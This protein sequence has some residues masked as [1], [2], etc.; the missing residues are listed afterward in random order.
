[1]Q[2]SVSNKRFNPPLETGVACWHRHR[3]RHG[4][5]VHAKRF[6][7]ATGAT[8][9]GALHAKVFCGMVCGAV[10]PQRDKPLFPKPDQTPNPTLDT[11]V[12]CAITTL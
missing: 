6:P 12:K 11:P 9:G 8:G 1:M 3:H 10:C 4:G 7:V 5:D 2:A